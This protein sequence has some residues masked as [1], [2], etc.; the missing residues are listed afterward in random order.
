MNYLVGAFP[1]SASYIKCAAK[2]NTLERVAEVKATWFSKMGTPAC[3]MSA[4]FSARS[5]HGA[6]FPLLSHVHLFAKKC[7]DNLIDLRLIVIIALLLLLCL[8]LLPG[9]GDI[10][11]WTSPSRAQLGSQ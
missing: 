1:S 2:F 8:I 9:V 5:R 6:S 4:I 7:S 3:Y 10:L 11:P